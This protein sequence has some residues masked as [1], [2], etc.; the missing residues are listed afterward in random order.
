MTRM[1]DHNGALR[2]DERIDV[3]AQVVAYWSP[4]NRPSPVYWGMKFSGMRK[5][6]AMDFINPRTWGSLDSRR[7][8]PE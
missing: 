4:A 5:C 2:H 3:V 1:M 6:E 7:G 8:S